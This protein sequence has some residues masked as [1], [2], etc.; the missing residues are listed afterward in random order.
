MIYKEF[1][2]KLKAR[3]YWHLNV[4][5]IIP[6]AGWGLEDWAQELKASLNNKIISPLTN[7][8][9]QAKQAKQASKQAPLTD[10]FQISNKQ[11]Y[12]QQENTNPKNL[13]EW[14]KL[15]IMW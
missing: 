12:R 9:K 4:V 10:T 1:N 5:P 8:H 15:T 6:E 14:V 13:L 3:C 7:Q 11:K 2:E